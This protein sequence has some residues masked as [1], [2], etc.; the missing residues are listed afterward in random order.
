MNKNMKKKLLK[1]KRDLIIILISLIISFTIS[2]TFYQKINQKI[3]LE[4]CFVWSQLQNIEDNS[5]KYL[6]DCMKVGNIFK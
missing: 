5:G 4:R 6:V 2:F 3:N 1:Y